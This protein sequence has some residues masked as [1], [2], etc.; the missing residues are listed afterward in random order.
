MLHCRLISISPFPLQPGVSLPSGQRH[1]PSTHCLLIFS[2][3]H[4]WLQLRCS[5]LQL[6]VFPLLKSPSLIPFFPSLQLWPQLSFSCALFTP[7]PPC[8]EPANLIHVLHSSRDLL[9]QQKWEMFTEQW[10]GAKLCSYCTVTVLVNHCCNICSGTQAAV[11][12]HT[13]AATMNVK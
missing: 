13:D 9:R 6:S 10:D 11:Q 5:T 7:L 2:H 8:L 4:S 1:G 12:V 3:I